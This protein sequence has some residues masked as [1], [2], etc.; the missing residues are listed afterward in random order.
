MSSVGS[1]IGE[2]SAQVAAER[3]G[4]PLMITV[5]TTSDQAKTRFGSP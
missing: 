3:G 1:R 5:E 2:V 4:E